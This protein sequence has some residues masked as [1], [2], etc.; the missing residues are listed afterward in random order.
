MDLGIFIFMRQNLLTS[1]ERKFN[2]LLFTG[3]LFG[4]P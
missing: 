2:L 1:H 4:D 3:G